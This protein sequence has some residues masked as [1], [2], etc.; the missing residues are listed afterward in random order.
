[1]K[2]SLRFGLHEPPREVNWWQ[3]I[4]NF[5]YLVTFKGVK[6]EFEM[7]AEDPTKRVEYICHFSEVKSYDP[8]Y[9]AD[10]YFDVDALLNTG[11][12]SKCECGAIYT[13]F[14]QFH[15]FFCPKWTKYG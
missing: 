4:K 13:S 11:Y 2:L 7:Y 15:M 5:P 10:T 3:P 1:M 12:G 8:N 9:Y 6:Y 14:P